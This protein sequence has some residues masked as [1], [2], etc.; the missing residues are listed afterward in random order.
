MNSVLVASIS[1]CALLWL[2]VANAACVTENQC[3]TARNCSQHQTCGDV[4]DVV[5]SPVNESATRAE[6][7]DALA[8]APVAAAVAGAGPNCRKVEICGSTQLVC[9]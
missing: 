4:R 6:P 9:E 1:A 5:Q 3:G 8:T 7:A 2:S